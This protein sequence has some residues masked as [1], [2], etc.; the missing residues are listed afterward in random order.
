MEHLF[1]ETDQH[2]GAARLFREMNQPG[3]VASAI[4]GWLPS[5]CTARVMSRVVPSL[6]NAVTMIC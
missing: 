3:L 1:L 2:G 5:Y 4:S 6:K